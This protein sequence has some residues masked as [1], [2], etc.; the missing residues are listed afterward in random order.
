MT[1]VVTASRFVSFYSVS[2][3]TGGV[4]SGEEG[5]T[6]VNAVDWRHT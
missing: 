5:T 2:I 3:I 4:R 1:I 6:G